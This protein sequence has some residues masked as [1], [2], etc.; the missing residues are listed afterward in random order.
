MKGLAVL[1]VILGAAACGESPTGIRD[2][3]KV[4][5]DSQQRCFL[6]DGHVYCSGS[7]TET[8]G[9]AGHQ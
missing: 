1:A 2:Q 6:I 8:V 4:A 7:T 9:T 3:P 5:F